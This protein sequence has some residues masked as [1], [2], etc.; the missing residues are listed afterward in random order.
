MIA[1]VCEITPKT[2]R[3]ML[4]MAPGTVQRLRDTVDRVRHRIDYPGTAKMEALPID[5][6][7]VDALTSLVECM[8]KVLP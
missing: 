7:D 2:V 8:L 3:V 6:P 5:R 4:T 1:A